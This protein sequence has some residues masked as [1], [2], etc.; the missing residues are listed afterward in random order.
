MDRRSFLK[1]A[2]AVSL[3][4]TAGDFAM[5]NEKQDSQRYN[6]IYIMA[7]DLGSKEVGCYGSKEMNTPFIDELAKGGTFFHTAYTVP[8]CVPSRVLVMSGRYATRTGY[9][10]MGERPGGPRAVEPPLNSIESE[11]SFGKLLQDMGYKTALAG[12]W[13]LQGPTSRWIPKAG[14]DEYCVWRGAGLREG[15]GSPQVNPGGRIGPQGSRYF[16][17]VI[18]QNGQYIETKPDDYGPDIYCNFLIDFMKKH[19]DEPFLL[20]YPMCL[21]HTPLGPTPD[22]P[23]LPV[24]ADIGLLKYKVKYMDKLVGRIVRAVDELG[25]REKTVIIFGSDNGTEWRGKNTPTERGARVPLVANCPGLIKAQGGIDALTDYSDLLPTFVDIAG[26]KLPEE[27]EFDGKSLAPVL[28]GKTKHHREWIFSYLGHY[29]V[30]RTADYLLEMEC[31]EYR[32]DFYYCRG[33]RNFSEYENVTDSDESRHIKARKE[34][35]KILEDLPAPELT[36]EQKIWLIRYLERYNPHF[37]DYKKTYPQK[38]RDNPAL[39]GSTMP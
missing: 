13:Q 34:F 19:K 33:K 32:G 18:E 3:A 12:K 25:L 20:Y 1:K 17:P 2:S 10:N 4:L 15:Y 27:Y 30:L 14:Y 11:P 16:H 24:K 5:A 9:Y 22:H 36:D 23:D 7:D 26:G 35:D 28:T 39:E 37:D 29:R 31:D 21:P 38:L 8:V 6:I